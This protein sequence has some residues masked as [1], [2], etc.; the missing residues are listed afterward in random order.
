VNAVPGVAGVDLQ[1]VATGDFGPLGELNAWAM[2]NNV[3]RF[4]VPNIVA[5]TLCVANRA[6]P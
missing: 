3:N 2:H 1:L 5:P 6:S 4:I